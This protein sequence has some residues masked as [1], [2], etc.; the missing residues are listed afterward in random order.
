MGMSRAR[1]GDYGAAEECYRSS[2]QHSFH[3][4]AL[5]HWFRLATVKGNAQQLAWFIKRSL[6]SGRLE[7]M[8]VAELGRWERRVKDLMAITREGKDPWPYVDKVSRE[9]P[10]IYHAAG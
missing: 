3:P 10:R 9:L 7:E 6:E 5:W 1:N 8:V 4:P 2:L